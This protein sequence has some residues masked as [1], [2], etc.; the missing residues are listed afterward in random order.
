[1]IVYAIKDTLTDRWWSHNRWGTESSI[2]DLYSSIEKA[3]HQIE[4]GKIAIN[5]KY[6]P[7]PVYPVVFELILTESDK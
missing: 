4:K 2:P 5:A 7:V 3:K 6:T 1:M